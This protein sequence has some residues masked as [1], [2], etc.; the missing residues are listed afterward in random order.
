[1]GTNISTT[2]MPYSVMPFALGGLY[3]FGNTKTKSQEELAQEADEKRKEQEAKKAE[4]EF[5]KRI[6]MIEKGNQEAE[7]A[8]AEKPLT[9]KE[10]RILKNAGL[11]IEQEEMENSEGTLSSTM[12]FTLPF[13]LPQAK[14]AIKP[15]KNTIEMFY[16]K[17]APHMDLFTKNP[18]L[19][20]NAQESMQK[21]ER[22]YAKDLKAAKGNS[23]LVNSIE[24][25]RNLLRN[26]MQ[27]ALDSGNPQGIAK[28][29]EQYK[30]ASTVK[31]GKLRRFFR[32]KNGQPTIRS[33]YDAVTS[34]ESAGKFSSVKVPKEGASFLRTLRTNKSIWVMTAVMATASIA[35]DWMYGNIK[36]AS[37]AD[38]KNKQ[39]GKI[40]NYTGSEIT[41]TGI[42]GTAG[43]LT[44][45]IADTSA[46]TLTK[47]CLG[48][49]AAK[50][51]TKIALKGGCK[52]LGAAVGSIVPGAGTAIGLVVGTVADFVLNKYVLSNMDY[53]KEPTAKKAEL[54][55]LNDEEL[56]G[57][58]SE[59][60]S[61]G[62][63]LDKKTIA[64]LKR[65]YGTEFNELKRVHNMSEKE[66]NEYFAAIQ[67]QQAQLAQQA[68]E[69]QQA[70]LAQQV[71]QQ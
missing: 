11:K 58:I 48:K 32:G 15:K 61:M 53:F 24:A 40:T 47:K 68:Q 69:G 17:D 71:Q 65:K 26:K 56:I 37:A 7:K 66:R 70:Q 3:N 45:T 8:E 33:R 2:F 52:I 35:M 59:Q 44:Y 6:E 21:L 54:N 16:K 41:K 27:I 63:K 18:D 30:T 60:Y 31:N 9:K 20:I 67:E 4:Q 36:K 10:K 55:S 51:A 34:A 49:F 19:M 12:L 25:E 38:E 46:R 50:L 57:Q 5:L 29:T 28:A 13:M 14:Q 22:K 23:V 64:L 43:A 39:N 62:N 1:M 42:K